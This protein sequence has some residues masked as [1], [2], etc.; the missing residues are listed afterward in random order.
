MSYKIISVNNFVLTKMK[1]K[2][3]EKMRK[4]YQNDKLKKSDNNIQKIVKDLCREKGIQNISFCKIMLL[5]YKIIE[6]EIK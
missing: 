1:F 4:T 6:D 3:V 5:Y 2:I